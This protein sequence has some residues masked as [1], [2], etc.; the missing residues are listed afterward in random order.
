[1]P[2]LV[3]LYIME[4]VIGLIASAAFVA[5]LLWLNVANLWHLM[6]HSDVGLLAVFLLWLFN[7]IVFSGVQFG[8]TIMLMGDKDD[9]DRGHKRPV[10]PAQ[11]APV[12]APVHLTVTQDRN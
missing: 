4:C 12:H 3:K 2:K 6:T 8:V 7:G 9:D 1:M 11:A 5:L 10:G